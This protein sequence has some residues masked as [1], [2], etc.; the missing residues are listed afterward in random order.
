MG[1]GRVEVSLACTECGARNYRT[2]RKRDQIL[3]IE[4]KKHC[5]TCNRHTLHRETK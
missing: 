3:Q 5:P 4:R 2:T 1:E